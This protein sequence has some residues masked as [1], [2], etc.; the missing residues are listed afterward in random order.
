MVYEGKSHKNGW[1]GGTPIY[2]YIY[3]ALA[4]VSCNFFQPHLPQVPRSCQFFK[5]F[6]V[7]IEL[8]IQPCTLSVYNFPR[9][10][11]A[12][13]ENRHPTSVT[14]EATLPE[15]NTEFCAQ[16]R[17]HPWIHRLPNC[18]LPLLLPLAN[19]FCSLCGWHDDKIAPGHSS[20]TREFSN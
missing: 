3:I 16:E 10:R 2:I 5:H 12:T 14:P 20:V 17:F 13:P 11:P 7:Q 15:K 18:Y 4:T 8:S 1:L 9:S 6:G 19:C